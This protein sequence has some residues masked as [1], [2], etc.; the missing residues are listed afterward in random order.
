METNYYI[1]TDDTEIMT[2]NSLANAI[3]YFGALVSNNEKIHGFARL[4]HEQDAHIICAYN[5][6]RKK[7]TVG[8]FM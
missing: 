4:V 2:F 8:K 6:L 3:L 5:F 1:V 7:Y